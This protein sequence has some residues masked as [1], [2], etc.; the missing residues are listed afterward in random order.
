MPG[1]FTGRILH[2][3]LTTGALD[4]ERPPESFYRTYLGG[5]AMGL[6]YI[7]RGMKPGTDGLHPDNVLT[8]MDSLLTGAPIAGQS[9]VT[10]NARSP[11]TDGIGDS[12]A[13]GFFPAELRFAGFTGIVITGRAA[14]PVYLWLH[15]GAAELRPAGHLWGKTT[16]AVDDLLK[17]ELGDDKIE[18]A[19]VG[20][21][22]EKLVR[23]AAIMN[24]ANRANGRTGMGAVMGSKNL[25]AIVARGTSKKLPLADAAGLN[26]LA[27]AGSAEI[28]NNADVLDLRT[29]GTE[30]VL[31]YQ[32]AS[33]TLPTFNYN[34]GQF[35]GYEAISG[36][37]MTA[38]ILRERD[39]CYACAVRC[40][41][42]VETEWQGRPVEPRHGGPE[43]ETA[44]VFGSYCGV[45]DLP[46]I[47]L[48]NKICNEHGLDTI[49]TGATVAWAMEC[50]EHGLVTEADLGFRA[51][52]GDTA[53]MVRL[54]EMLATR[55]G[56]GDVL[57]NGSRRAADL[58]GKGHQFLITVKGAEA[59]AHMPQAKRT[60]G[61]IYAVNPFGADHQSSEHDPM[62]E[63]GASDLSLERLKLLGF[64][65]A[66]PA[67]SFGPEKVR[68]AL[69]TQQFYSF[70]D[71][72]SL[73]QFVWGP[74]WSL[75]G[76]QEA[77]DLVRAVTGWADFDVAEL[78]EIGERRLNML[79]AFN[80]REGI[81]R[82]EDRLPE[83][84]FR[85]LAG[86]GPTAGIALDPVEIEGALDEYYRLA[87]WDGR[88]GNPTP[89][90][91]A[92][93]GLEWTAAG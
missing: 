2:V 12:Q 47:S 42:V 57:A 24:M 69:R 60:L 83:K 10:V 30:G 58:L 85:P 32:H 87:G 93:L 49:G 88:T 67:G 8:V 27:R 44:A 40:K 59:P 3:D 86:T 81:G 23:L 39:T 91:M 7:L 77:V 4:V 41:R 25:K 50:F 43:Y 46:A 18:V 64:D 62:I 21:A 36:Q 15:D 89:E 38:T 70:L 34:A 33:G 37:T 63:E 73:C 75:Y 5:S 1:E 22:G 76:P 9:R 52:F 72:A 19:Q 16:S 29:N 35:D 11:L 66:L 6:Y 90:T 55:E 68:F 92:R 82:R 71:T 56:F 61:V 17:A 26:K 20:P 48:A 51:P 28:P 74:A 31:E 54:T 45:D 65:G 53:A 13:G 79:R 84:F 14:E 78:M 80:A